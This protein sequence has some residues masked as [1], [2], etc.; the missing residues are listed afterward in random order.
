MISRVLRI[1]ALLAMSLIASCGGDSGDAS[2]PTITSSPASTSVTEGGS[3]SLS[4]AASGPSLLYQWRKDGM[5]ILGATS[6]TYTIAPVAASDAGSYDVIV[7]NSA[8]AVTSSASTLTVNA[9]TGATTSALSPVVYAAAL[10]FYNTLS[11]SQQATAQLSWSLDTARR[12]SNLPTTLVAR[13]GIAWADLSTT[14]QMAAAMLIKAALSS[15]GARLHLGLQAADDYLYANGGGSSYGHGNYYIAFLGTPSTSGFWML[16]LTGH[17]LTYNIAFNGS[18][19]S[20]APM[21]LGV[22]PKDAFTLDGRT[23]DPMAAQRTA[24]SNLGA[25]LTAYADAKL[26]GTYADLLFGANGAGNIDGTCPRDYAS[27]TEHGVLYSSL[28]SSDQ[29]LVRA[30]ITSY[31]NTQATEYANDLLNAYL[32]TAALAQTYVAYAGSGTVTTKGNYFR[33]EG[34]RVWIEFSVQNGVIFNSDIHYH[35]IWRDKSADYGGKCIG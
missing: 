12:W 11:A 1:A 7:S 17:H 27:V 31:V 3:A 15:T 21:F 30:A 8:G 9:A 24:V 34:P 16:Q 18:Y 23:Y 32:G 4:V 29:A 6:S 14:Q 13:N 28:S 10:R 19:M 20:A 2:S 35:S 33:I 26:N 25:A 22:E 5:W